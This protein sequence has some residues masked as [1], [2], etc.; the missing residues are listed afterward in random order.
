MSNNNIIEM[1]EILA[2]EHQKNIL[3]GGLI[4]S[5]IRKIYTDNDALGSHPYLKSILK[6]PTGFL[7]K[8]ES[9]E[10]SRRI[11]KSILADYELTP[12]DIVLNPEQEPNRK[13]V[14]TKKSN[15]PDL[16]T[17][18]TADGSPATEKTVPYNVNKMP[19]DKWAAV[20]YAV[21]YEMFSNGELNPFFMRK[22]NIP[23]S[24]I[25]TLKNNPEKMELA[26][27]LHERYVAK[28]PFSLPSNHYQ[29][30]VNDFFLSVK[31]NDNTKS[32]LEKLLRKPKKNFFLVP[33][34]SMEQRRNLS[35][36][37]SLNHYFT[38]LSEK[39]GDLSEK[40]V[41]FNHRK[42]GSS[43]R[44]DEWIVDHFSFMQYDHLGY[45]PDS[46]I[47]RIGDLYKRMFK[48][49]VYLKK[50]QEH[51]K[52]VG[53]LSSTERLHLKRRQEIRRYSSFI[54]YVFL[55]SLLTTA[56]GYVSAPNNQIK[57]ETNK[58]TAKEKIKAKPIDFKMEVVY[59]KP[60]R[61][62]HPRRRK[63]H[64]HVTADNELSYQANAEISVEKSRGGIQLETTIPNIDYSTN[65]TTRVNDLFKG[66]S[67]DGDERHN[68]HSSDIIANL[69][70]GDSQNNSTTTPDIKSLLGSVDGTGLEPVI[71]DVKE[72]GAI[73]FIVGAFLTDIYKRYKKDDN[74][75]YKNVK[76]LKYNYGNKEI[77]VSYIEK[78]N[79]LISIIFG[80]DPNDK[81]KGIGFVDFRSDGYRKGEILLSKVEGMVVAY[82][83]GDGTSLTYNGAH[84]SPD[85]TKKAMSYLN[86][87]Y[88][89]FGGK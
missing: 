7:Q 39:I 31:H 54:K 1:Q 28:K 16:A 40:L 68:I 74:L 32:D 87:F 37:L 18:T 63:S 12:D 30:M 47:E 66:N 58:V 5:D 46:L 59:L 76:F 11:L 33:T 62:H 81:N 6:D 86:N 44:V 22:F 35:S 88:R 25:D 4:D 56:I 57:K 38:D 83:S 24:L 72:K 2:D 79:S 71:S 13:R 41:P 75:T 20:K 8:V 80:I 49:E 67:E 45:H 89:E 69:T 19:I 82:R 23:P 21:A 64:Q 42:D 36:G 15:I 43:N 77:Y 3:I 17:R 52:N 78:T 84:P 85:D 51:E 34:N 65:L 27:R 48:G 73:D 61:Y 55:A 29:R 70:I 26:K 14:D 60:T 53:S 9:D 10:L 50:I